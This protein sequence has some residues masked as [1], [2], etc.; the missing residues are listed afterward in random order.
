MSKERTENGVFLGKKMAKPP[1]DKFK[2]TVSTERDHPF[3]Q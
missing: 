3:S 2:I 1:K